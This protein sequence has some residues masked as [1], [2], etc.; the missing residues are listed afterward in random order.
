MYYGWTIKDKE[1]SI[2]KK[3]YL[4]LV[5]K[6]AF[7]SV[8]KNGTSLPLYNINDQLIAIRNFG[9]TKIS[10]SKM[11]SLIKE[12]RELTVI[13]GT[14]LFSR[15]NLGVI[16]D[17]NFYSL[18]SPK[19]REK[20]PWKENGLKLHVGNSLTIYHQKHMAF[21]EKAI[22]FLKNTTSREILIKIT[23]PCIEY[24]IYLPDLLSNDLKEE[25][26]NK[27]KISSQEIE[28]LYREKLSN[29]GKVIITRKEI[30]DVPEEYGIPRDLKSY[31]TAYRSGDSNES[32]LIIAIDDIAETP[33]LIEA[34]KNMRFLVGILGILASAPEIEKEE[35]S[36]PYLI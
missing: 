7:G 18:V 19:D 12:G 9:K 16:Y 15:S 32:N 21:M 28:N 20:I 2:G 26:W 27:I 10:E 24:K 29:L 4:S 3:K 14:C 8:T 34:G 33:L 13:G 25:Y 17:E 1:E 5:G 11:A 35:E 36:H 6:E 22:C 31:I 23:I 30:W